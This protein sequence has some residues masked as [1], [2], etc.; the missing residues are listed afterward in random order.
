MAKVVSSK[1][2][3]LY[4]MDTLLQKSDEKHRVSTEELQTMLGRNGIKAE[5]R[6]IYDDI[7]TLKTWGMDILHSKEQP[8]GY[9]LASRQFELPELKL[10][11]DAVQSSKFI[12]EKKSRE[13]IKKLESM[14]SVYE[15]RLIQR[16]VYV[17][18]R[19]KAQNES[20]YYNVDKIHEA[21]SSDVK[22]CFIYY[23]WNTKK[24]L[25][26]RNGGKCFEISP[27]ALTWDDE[28]YYMIGY[29]D[30][31]GL[32]KHYRVDKMKQIHLMR[33]KRLGQD[34]FEN[35]DIA[36]FAKSTFGMYG[37]RKE[38]VT[39]ECKNPLIGAILDRFGTDMIIAN[40]GENHFQVQHRVA[41][42]GQ[43]FGWLVGLG[44]DIKIVG[45]KS[46]ADE[47]KRWIEAIYGSYEED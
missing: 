16:Q 19:I 34:S 22:I 27:W 1:L 44:A 40:T 12:T 18:N 13:L 45:P 9:Y 43:F 8:A 14:A 11:V 41:V 46:V 10:L 17:I 5:R 30:K 23:K 42:S 29:D 6:S 20:I 15:A 33:K 39:L 36:C 32:V 25:V 4:I 3:T 24:E 35:F 7:E 26:P 28:N 2:R 47:F 38:L 37:G 31:A 21:I